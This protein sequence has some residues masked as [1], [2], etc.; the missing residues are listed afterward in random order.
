[1]VCGCAA[2]KN[3]SRGQTNS[4][5]ADRGSCRVAGQAHESRRAGHVL[6]RRDG[7]NPAHNLPTDEIEAPSGA[8]FVP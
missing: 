2:A 7:A 8:S 1:V 3:M 5:Y 4:I 6:G